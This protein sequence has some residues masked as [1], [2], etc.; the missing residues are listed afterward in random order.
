MVSQRNVERFARLFKGFSRAY[1]RFTARNIDPVSKKVEGIPATIAEPVTIERY[2]YHLRGAGADSLGIIVL[3]D[4]LTCDFAAIDIDEPRPY[5]D[6]VGLLARARAKRLPPFVLCQSKSKT[7]HLFFFFAT[8]VPAAHVMSGL[9]HWRAMLGL[10]PRTE[11]FPKQATRPSE[12]DLGS[13]I[14]LP[15]YG[16]DPERAAYD[17]VRG[18]GWLGLDAFL[19]LAE[20][21]RIVEAQFAPPSADDDPEWNVGPPCLATIAA[22]GGIDTGAR[23]QLLYNVGVYLKKRYGDDDLEQRLVEYNFKYCRPPQSLR[24][25]AATAKSLTRKNYGFKCKEEPICSYCNR[26]V[27]LTRKY[28]V[29]PAF[30]LTDLPFKIERVVVRMS[31]PVQ[32]ELTIAGTT[33][34]VHQDVITN[35]AKLQSEIFSVTRLVLPKMK[36]GDFEQFLTM[37]GRNAEVIEAPIDA[38]TMGQVL[39]LV[40]RFCLDDINRAKTRDEIVTGKPFHDGDRVMFLSTALLHY[41][42]AN[43]RGLSSQDTGAAVVW[44]LLENQRQALSEDVTVRRRT[45]QVWSITKPDELHDDAQPAVRKE[46]F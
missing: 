30:T 26:D 33:L 44:G 24:D 42:R 38:G 37:L 1:G 29:R 21:R 13:W 36:Q 7:C 32:W 9:A 11:I 14:N 41:L 43:M 25:V 12:Q 10:S 39:N 18:G 23:N 4:D 22:Q 20:S 3:G 31:D 45:Y 19:D 15:Y 40:D 35:Q 17:E 28:G 16:R 6:Y 5:T 27:C 2:A 8:P 46:V 34:A